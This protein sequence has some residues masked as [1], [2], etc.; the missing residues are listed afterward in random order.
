[1]DDLVSAAL[2]DLAPDLLGRDLTLI[3]EQLPSV[4]GDSE[5]LQLV[6]MNLLQNA[7]KYTGKTERGDL[8]I[9]ARQGA[10]IVPPE[11]T[12]L[13]A[14]CSTPASCSAPFNVWTSQPT[15]HSRVTS[16]HLV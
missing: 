14:I 1:M 8:E 6:W 3:R 11:T 13:D 12:V 10:E 4:R 2:Q 9:G 5:M 7:I 16:D 15:S